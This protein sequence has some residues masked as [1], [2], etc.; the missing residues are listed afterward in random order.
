MLDKYGFSLKEFQNYQKK[1]L[2]GKIPVGISYTYGNR[3]REY[4]RRERKTN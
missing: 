2:D 3:L 4:F 1:M